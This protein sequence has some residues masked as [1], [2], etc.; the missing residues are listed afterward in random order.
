V[1]KI[2]PLSLDEWFAVMKISLPVIG[3]DEGLKF[4]SRNYVDGKEQSRV[5]GLLIVGVWWAGFAALLY[6]SPLY[7]VDSFARFYTHY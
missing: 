4:L 7:P 5:P 6:Y 1:F 2:C 3:L